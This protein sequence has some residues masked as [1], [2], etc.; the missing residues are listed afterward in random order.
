VTALLLLAFAL[1]LANLRL[2]AQEPDFTAAGV[3][4]GASFAAGLSP[5]AIVTIFGKGLTKDVKGVILAN[6]TPLP[7]ELAGTSVLFGTIAAPLFAI[8]N[9]NGQEQINLLVPYELTGQKSTT[10]V[11]NNNGAKS[12]A[13]TVDVLETFPGIFTVDGTS[14]AILTADNR[15]VTSSNPAKRG[16]VVVIYC[17]GLGPVSPAPKTGASAAASPLS[18]TALLPAVTIGGS[19]ADVLFSGLAPGFAGLYQ[20]NV[21]VPALGPSGN[22]DVVIEA[23]GVSSKVVKLAV[24]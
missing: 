9:V 13:V 19:K 2:Q 16:E 14:G 7:D 3:V 6:K 17:T 22:L 8:A 21:R 5:G 12:A 15:L 11:V 10:I 24:Q 18:L 1:S 4:N 20:V 23:G